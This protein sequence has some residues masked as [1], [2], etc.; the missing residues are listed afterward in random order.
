[1]IIV[2]ANLRGLVP[3]DE[4]GRLL[5]DPRI[6]IE[7][8]RITIFLPKGGIIDLGEFRNISDTRS[9]RLQARDRQR[10]FVNGFRVIYFRVRPLRFIY[11]EIER[12]ENGVDWEVRH[13]DLNQPTYSV[14]IHISG[15]MGISC[16][17]RDLERSERIIYDSIRS[18]LAFPNDDE[19]RTRLLQER[20]PISY[21][22]AQLL[23]RYIANAFDRLRSECGRLERV[24]AEE[25]DGSG[26]NDATS[27]GAGLSL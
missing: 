9:F 6:K 7:E 15:N 16:V 13:F 1:M 25:F 26:S 2:K 23:S 10:T 19:D 14:F 21:E 20:M 18:R 12:D 22:E 4:Y 27:G 8:G 11:P 5:N 17:H 24:L 3:P